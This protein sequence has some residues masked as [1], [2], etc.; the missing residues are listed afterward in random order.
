MTQLL[1]RIERLEDFRIAAE[2]SVATLLER[3]GNLAIALERNTR[4]IEEFGE[5]LAERRGARRQLRRLRAGAYAGATLGLV[6][7]GMLADRIWP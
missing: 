5:E 3:A 1:D 7:L 2:I 6:G 4:A